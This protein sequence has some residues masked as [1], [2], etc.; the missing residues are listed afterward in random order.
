MIGNYTA[1][2]FFLL[3]NQLQCD[4][5]T[6]LKPTERVSRNALPEPSV[7]IPENGLQA[8]AGVTLY[9]DSKKRDAHAEG[10]LSGKKGILVLK[11]SRI[12]LN[13]RLG[14]QTRQMGNEKSA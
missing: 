7:E 3:Q 4:A 6:A 9:I 10:I 14:M 11:G 12:S 8:L 5:F 1:F 13:S 2:A